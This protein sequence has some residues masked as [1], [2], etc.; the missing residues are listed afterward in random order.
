M[1]VRGIVLTW[2]DTHTERHMT[3]SETSG[4]GWARLSD[5]EVEHMRCIAADFVARNGPVP[6]SLADTT[7]A[8][9]E[10]EQARRREPGYVP[11]PLP[12]PTRED[13]ARILPAAERVLADLV[14]VIEDATGDADGYFPPLHQLHEARRNVAAWTQEHGAR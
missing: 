10:R 8:D 1:T 12:R 9:A 4:I 14:A 7:L 11:P 3:T 5:D 13:I 2:G 6:G